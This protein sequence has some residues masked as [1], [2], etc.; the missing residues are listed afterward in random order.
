MVLRYRLSRSFPTLFIHVQLVLQSLRMG[1]VS[2]CMVVQ[3]VWEYIYF[4][5]LGNIAWGNGFEACH[6]SPSAGEHIF[7]CVI[8]PVVQRVA[9]S[10]YDALIC[11]YGR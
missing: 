9:R 1:Q 4:W 11:T 5:L 6:P 2:L 3:I 8:A 10:A 7:F